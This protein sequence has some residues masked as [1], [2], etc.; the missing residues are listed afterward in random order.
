MQL[1][2]AGSVSRAGVQLIIG[3]NGII[4][5]SAETKP[6]P[7][8]LKPSVDM[9]AQPS[10][11]RSVSQAERHAIARVANCIR[12]L[13]KLFFSIHPTS[14]LNVY[15]VCTTCYKVQIAWSFWLSAYC[16]F[17]PACPDPAQEVS[18]TAA[19][20]LAMRLYHMCCLLGDRVAWSAKV[21]EFVLRLIFFQQNTQELQQWL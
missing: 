14:I 1:R 5:V 3:L 7:E 11:V 15:T 10:A 4:W 8:A 19:S 21:S 13:A 20:A 2:L 16:T 9:D 12:A 6:A 17:R 18:Y